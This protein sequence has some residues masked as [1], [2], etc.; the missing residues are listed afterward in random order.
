MNLMKPHD[1][2]PGFR[3][4]ERRYNNHSTNSIKNATMFIIDNI[5]SSSSDVP[6]QTKFRIYRTINRPTN[7]I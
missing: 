3:N 6:P 5:T 7:Q 4:Q 2:A 1:G